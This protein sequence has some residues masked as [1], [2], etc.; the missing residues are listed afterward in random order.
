MDFDI[1]FSGSSGNA[2][3][4]EN[5][6]FDIGV[7]PKNDKMK[8]L[9]NECNQ[10]FVSHKHGDHL[11]LM[12][13]K[14]ISDLYPLTKIYVNHQTKDFIIKRTPK[15]NHENLIEFHDREQLLLDD[16]M[17]INI[18]E[19]KHE[20]STISTAY[21]GITSDLE[22]F[23]F[24]TD[25]YDFNDLPQDKSDYF[26]IEANHDENYAWYL[27]EIQELGG[28]SL[29]PWILKS[30][31]RHTTKQAAMKYYFEHR[32][33]DNSKFVPLHKSSRFYDMQEYQN[34]I[35]ELLKRGE[36]K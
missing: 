25:F 33:S 26:F 1:A 28:P 5:T 20:E 9:I 23:V 17:E 22:E 11:N 19:T 32:S 7:T 14:Y 29:K 27:K 10:V 31:G 30:T 18:F 6:L 21:K 16:G 36:K 3:R 2:I 13:Y 35:D 34:Q 4:I 24:A 12:T 8:S 15:Y